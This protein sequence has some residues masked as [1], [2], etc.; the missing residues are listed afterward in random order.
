MVEANK[1]Y[2]K[3][4]TLY[5][6][7]RSKNRNIIWHCRCDCGNELKKLVRKIET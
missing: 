4:T 3:L 1:K 2:G 6:N 7:G 5:K